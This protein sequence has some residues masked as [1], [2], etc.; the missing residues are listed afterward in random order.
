MV[1]S[2]NTAGINELILANES[3]PY[4]RPDANTYLNGDYH[5]AVM[6]GTM[7]LKML[8]CIDWSRQAEYDASP[9]ELYAICP[10]YINGRKLCYGLGYNKVTSDLLHIPSPDHKIPRSK[11]GSLKI[12]NLVIVPLIYNIWKRDIVKEDWIQFRTWMDSHLEEQ[13]VNNASNNSN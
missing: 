13:D 5:L 12:D 11:D 7:D 6:R 8:R 3:E 2:L 4:H 1:T 10:D 9:E